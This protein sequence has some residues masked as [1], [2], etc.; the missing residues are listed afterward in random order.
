[1][2]IWL[3]NLGSMKNNILVFGRSLGSGP[4]SFLAAKK[5]PGMLVLMSPFTS[6]KDVAGSLVGR[7][8]KFAVKD[9]F[10]NKDNMEEVTWPV[11]ILH[12]E[13]DSLIPY[14][15]AEELA[16]KWKGVTDLRIPPEM[17]HNNFDFYDD[18]IQPLISFMIKNN[19]LVHPTED[20]PYKYAELEFPEELFDTP[21]WHRIDANRKKML[22]KSAVRN[23]ATK[24]QN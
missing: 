22:A 2:S 3:K 8:S 12:G 17:D 19:I 24:W 9:V 1:M 21:R 15:H 13:E 10:R 23:I 20:Y 5:N 7:W 16:S 14:S 11:Y 6:I 4:A 18:L